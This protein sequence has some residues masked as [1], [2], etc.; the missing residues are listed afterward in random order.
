ML[1]KVGENRPFKGYQHFLFRVT[2]RG[3]EQMS[4][5]KSVTIPFRYCSIE[6]ASRFLTEILDQSIEIE[7]I[8]NYLRL[9][10]V[11]GCVRFS[12]VIDEPYHNN[13][14]LTA[15][16]DAVEFSNATDFDHQMETRL[17][18]FLSSYSK[19]SNG[20]I[21][22]GIIPWLWNSDQAVSQIAPPIVSEDAPYYWTVENEGIDGIFVE[23][24]AM[25]TGLWEIQTNKVNNIYDVV[26]LHGKAEHDK[27]C[28]ILFGRIPA[29]KYRW[30]GYID[31]YKLKVENIVLLDEDLKALIEML[32]DLIDV[33][34]LTPP[35]AN[36]SV[37]G[38]VGNMSLPND[39]MN[40]RRPR[41]PSKQ[42]KNILK[43]II[44]IHPELGNEC[45][46]EPHALH[47]KLSCLFATKGV[48]LPPIS[49]KS[50]GDYINDAS[51]SPS[52][53]ES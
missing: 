41:A 1:S 10:V 27:P 36:E 40:H 13:M 33:H 16:I 43:A 12:S 18:D 2:L 38:Y 15:C 37:Q 31:E 28:S 47:Y 51:W 39:D 23:V 25:A 45:L 20:E 9:G 26:F 11:R 3:C 22:G 6:R 34:L 49:S 46:Q 29:T 50:L 21:V 24:P 35:I 14:H 44:S 53:T 17:N 32:N 4:K 19:S 5:N 42:L 48:A 8:Q 7:D 52:S 30:H